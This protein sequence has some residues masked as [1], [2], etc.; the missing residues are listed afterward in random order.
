MRFSREAAVILHAQI[1]LF[2][3]AGLR[4]KLTLVNIRKF[5]LFFDIGRA[6]FTAK[7]LPGATL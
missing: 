4:D 2:G 1:L 7:S 5:R 6:A 3:I